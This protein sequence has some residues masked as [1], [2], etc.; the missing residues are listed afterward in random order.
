[1]Y[2]FFTLFGVSFIQCIILEGGGGNLCGY[3]SDVSSFTKTHFFV[4]S[5]LPDQDIDGHS[6]LY[7]CNGS[8]SVKVI[9]AGIIWHLK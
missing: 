7:V 5:S 1:M 2:T 6:K 9:L 8:L 3:H 4:V